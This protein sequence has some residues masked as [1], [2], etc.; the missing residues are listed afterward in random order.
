[1]ERVAHEGTRRNTTAGFS[2]SEEDVDAVAAM[3]LKTIIHLQGQATWLELEVALLRRT[4]HFYGVPRDTALSS[5]QNSNLSAA[6]TFLVNMT[7]WDSE[8]GWTER[9]A[10]SV[11]RPAS[12]RPVKRLACRASD[13]FWLIVPGP[14][15]FCTGSGPALRQVI[16]L[17][18][19]RHQMPV[20]S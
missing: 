2:I 10:R 6:V 19:T 14:V 1:M 11:N 5:V 7:S 9:V 3:S 4:R 18:S 20:P 15:Q 16:I 8:M 13:M 12:Y 17:H